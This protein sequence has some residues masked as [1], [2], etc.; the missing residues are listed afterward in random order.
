[1]AVYEVR[2]T[3]HAPAVENVMPR[4]RDVKPVVPSPAGKAVDLLPLPGRRGSEG[5]RRWHDRGKTGPAEVEKTAKTLIRLINQQLEMLNIQIHLNLFK[6]EDGY[7]LDVHD[8]RD[9]K[10]CEKVA[11]EPIEI[12]E[13]PDLLERL[14]QQGGIL[15]DTKM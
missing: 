10:V 1:M 4:R 9:G 7:S 14:R 6:D 2:D 5:E 11:E 12:D 8:C 15:L 3:K 13:L